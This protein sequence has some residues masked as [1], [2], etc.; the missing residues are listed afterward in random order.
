MICVVALKTALGICFVFL[1][2]RAIDPSSLERAL[3]RSQPPYLVASLVSKLAGFLLLAWRSQR[4]LAPQ[5]SAR[6]RFLIRSH[7]VAFAG[8]NLL[9]LRAGE[10][11][12]VVLVKRFAGV[13]VRA[14][15]SIAV[16]ERL[17]DV[18]SLALLILLLLGTTGGAGPMPSRLVQVGVFA[19]IFALTIVLVALAVRRA[20]KRCPAAL[21]FFARPVARR[22]VKWIG[23]T[24]DQSFD[25]LTGRK[26]AA[27]GFL[28][29]AFWLS[30]IV[31]A[32]L[33]IEGMCL[34]LPWYAPLLVVA[35]V[36]LAGALP[37]TPA[38]VGTYHYAAFAAASLSGADSDRAIAFSLIAHAF[39]IIP[40]T[41]TGI[42]MG[43]RDVPSLLEESLQTRQ[44][45]GIGTATP[46]D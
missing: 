14:G 22:V 5:H 20:R 29:L 8:N 11:L 6:F 44:S 43:F 35:F 39:S 31:S 27:C 21:L 16:V 34:E 42:A 33:W 28:T 18:W 15:L 46:L 38:Q 41:L 19:G 2:V 24:V 10:M 9:P 4:L 37:A 26:L 13:P 17:L 36:S 12:R 30:S 3:A 1:L 25:T 23:E 32:A 40:F 7:L 45:R